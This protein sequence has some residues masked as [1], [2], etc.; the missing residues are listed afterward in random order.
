M[1]VAGQPSPGG[2]G[3]LD[4]RIARAVRRARLAA[5]WEV[6]WRRLVP[7]AWVAGLHV[8]LAW[9]GV[10]AALPPIARWGLLA[11]V[12]GLLVFAVVAAFR[13]LDEFAAVSG[14]GRA[15]RR[16]EAES[17]LAGHE[18]DGLTDRLAGSGD[19]ATERLWA[20]HRARLAARVGRLASG[21]P[22][23][24]LGRRDVWAA[25]PI[26]ALLL[27]IGWSSASG[28]HL[29]R[30]VSPFT[31]DAPAAVDDRLDAWIDPPAYT[32]RA[33]LV[34]I[35][36]GRS[37]VG[38]NGPD[39]VP[40]VPQG[41]RLV[42]RAASGRADRPPQPLTLTVAPVGGEATEVAATPTP[43]APGPTAQSSAPVTSTERMAVLS[44]DAEV[45]L[46]RDGR[47][48]AGW[49]ITVVPDRPPTI[50]L[51]G[52]PEVQASGAMKLTHE[53]GD[54][55]GVVAAEARFAAADV[56]K[57]RALYEPP[58]FPLAL[59]LGRAHTGIARTIR[60]VTA[61]PFAGAT[62]RMTLVARDEA[63]QEGASPP[64]EVT[65]P[66]RP[67]RKPLARALTELRRRL[68]LD[69]GEAA[70][71]VTALEALT[72][73]PDRFEEKPGTHLGLR[74]LRH[75]AAAA[76]DDEALRE[77]VELLWAAATTIEDGDL[78]DHERALRDAQEA[79]RRALEEGASPEEIARLTRE[80]RQAMDKF[81]AAKAEQSRR[82]TR[83]PTPPGPRRT[84][85]ERDIRRMLDRIEDLA[86]T[87][88]REAAEKLL[89]ELRELTENL[90]S[91]APAEGE[92]G[93]AGNEALEKLGEMIHRQQQLMEETHRSRRDGREA[94]SNEEMGRI[95]RGQKD[96]AE[97]LGK[98]AEEMG[99]GE[100]GRRDEFG[101]KRGPGDGSQD[102]GEAADAM[103]EAADALERGE[104]EAALDS[105]AQALDKLRRGARA[106]ADRMARRGEGGR[107][108]DEDPLGRPRRQQGS[109]DGDKVRVPDEIDVERARR[110][111]DE[112]RKRLGEPVRPK[113]E[114][115]YL[116]RLLKLDPGDR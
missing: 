112:I 57:G 94:E 40:A 35:A 73:A 71:V 62:M 11:G 84:I 67:F 4:R 15:V 51:I 92:D 66:Q 24:D 110:V 16:V 49:K 108:G 77:V 34:L 116:D 82:Q 103:G 107:D 69:V 48:V 98:F 13:N 105:Q 38:S 87:G 104:G 86:R 99:G 101:R 29:M 61:H 75:K 23:P 65:L 1:N 76:R 54:D 32:G 95:G 41:S 7:I 106:L 74:F 17:G 9:L 31:S 100:A 81:L 3:G 36:E 88:S 113:F 68:A 5:A 79:L 83:G 46:A 59:P 47:P 85:T 12:A 18:L 42:V 89:E 43:A 39:A 26:L 30:L 21:W 91:G 115:D 80:L 93:Q 72:M 19:A 96:L 20:V 33:P 78:A 60:D 63:G 25:R 64:I 55:W 58:S 27:F 114:R 111:L 2:S 109:S 97:A 56:P 10:Y 6:V 28:E 53:T 50:A 102:L 70:T 90:Q 52:R 45:R 8:A 14:E 37:L 44:D 22:H